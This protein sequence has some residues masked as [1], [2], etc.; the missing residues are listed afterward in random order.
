[1]KASLIASGETYVGRIPKIRVWTPMDDVF[2]DLILSDNGAYWRSAKE[3]NFLFLP[4]ET[5]EQLFESKG[6]LKSAGAL[7]AA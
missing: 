3:N 5:L 7:G 4:W 2:G 6:A 1:M